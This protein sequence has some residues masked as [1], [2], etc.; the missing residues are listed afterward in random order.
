[1][2]VLTSE[3]LTIQY[4]GESPSG[5][6]S[7]WEVNAARSGALLGVVRWFGRW[8]Q[9]A[10]FPEPGTIYSVGCMAD[11]ETFIREQMAERRRGGDHATDARAET[12]NPD[13]ANAERATS[14]AGTRRRGRVKRQVLA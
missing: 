11:I 7:T 9:Y 3:Y 5:K 13:A 8:R 1:M 10:F 14:T 12:R 4:A 2:P 6:T